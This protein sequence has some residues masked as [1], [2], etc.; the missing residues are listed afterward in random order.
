MV[1]AAALFTAFTALNCCT[2][3]T[4]LP[5]PWT[6][7]YLAPAA[8]YICCCTPESA[9]APT[10]LVGHRQHSW[11]GATWPFRL[12]S[13]CWRPSCGCCSDGPAGSH[14]ALVPMARIPRCLLCEAP[15][16]GAFPC[17]LRLT[18]LIP[19]TAVRDARAHM[20]GLH[21]DGYSHQLC[22]EP[23]NNRDTCCTLH[24]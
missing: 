18:L 1:V 8:T 20:A 12:L 7:G 21:F 16:N 23:C 14:R 10:C 19:H 9:A 5:A 2:Q 11:G 22:S 4:A 3:G 17:P 15:A 13:S 6:A 24:G